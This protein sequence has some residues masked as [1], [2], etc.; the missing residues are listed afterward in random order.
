MYIYSTSIL[1][2]EIYNTEL[3]DTQSVRLSDSVT[4][5]KSKVIYLQSL[6]NTRLGISLM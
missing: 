3:D 2:P 5:G 4:I 1:K 6:K